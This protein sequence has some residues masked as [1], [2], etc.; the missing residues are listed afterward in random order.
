MKICKSCGHEAHA[1]KCTR[2][3]PLGLG[4]TICRCGARTPVSRGDQQAIANAFDRL[5]R[6]LLPPMAR[7]RSAAF[8]EHVQIEVCG[9]VCKPTAC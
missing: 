7:G 1:G 5:R 3:A 8:G 6:C 2:L 4:W 9:R